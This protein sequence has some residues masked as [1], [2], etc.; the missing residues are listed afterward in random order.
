[1]SGLKEKLVARALEEGFIACRICRPDAVPDVAARLKAFVDAGYHGQ[2]TW[3]ADRM[4][5]RGDPTQLWPQAR[6]V[7][8][9]A[10]S[11]GPEH[12][13]M[14]VLQQPERGAISVYAQGRDYHDVVKKRLKRLARWLMAEAADADPQVKVFVDTAPVP[15]KALGQAAGLGWQGKHTNLLSREWGNWAFLGAVFTT[16]DIAPDA[17]EVDHCGSCRAC[18]DVCPTDA[19]PAP[20]K[21]DARRCISY[22]T[23]EHKGPVPTDLRPLLGNRIYGCDDCLAVC[24]WNKFATAARDMR[25]SARPELTAPRL[26]DLAALDDAAFRA[27]FSGSAVKRIGRNRFVRNVLYAIGNSGEA[28]LRQ[29]ASE[30]TDDPDDAVADAARWAVAQLGG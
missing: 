21:L 10:E 2:M 1:M 19:F 4:H 13:P 27:L 15:E 30:L 29:I 25:L 5:W 8:M 17:A 26:A 3:M 28:S 9:L 14:A 23:I 20:Y 16:L 11:Y 7:I 24:P 6:S 22:L 18:L 12:D